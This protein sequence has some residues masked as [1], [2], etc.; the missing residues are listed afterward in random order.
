MAV[1]AMNKTFSVNNFVS[2]CC[3]A[4]NYFV[5]CN[6]ICSKC[7]KVIKTLAKDEELTINT[8]I[9][10]HSDKSN[11][12]GDVVEIFENTAKRF[13]HDRTCEECNKTCPKCKCPHARYLRNQQDKL[14]FVCEQCRNV[15]SN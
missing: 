2:P 14:I 6:I 1:I 10:E 12:S 13:A 5:G 11:I 8:K 3:N 7:G 9:N 4:F 15:M